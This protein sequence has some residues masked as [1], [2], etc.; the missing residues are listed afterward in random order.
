MHRSRFATAGRYIQCEVHNLNNLE[1]PLKSN[2][3]EIDVIKKGKGR[4]MLRLVFGRS[5]FV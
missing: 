3:G 5:V 2:E 4:N 1:S